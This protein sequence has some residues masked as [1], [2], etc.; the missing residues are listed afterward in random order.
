[1][2]SRRIAWL[3]IVVHLIGL[4]PLVLLLWRYWQGG[5]KP[6]PIGAAMRHT[7]RYALILLLLSL[8]PTALR[9][10][11]DR[12]D[13][14]R[15]R[16]AVGL[17]AFLYAA[18]HLLIYVGLDYAFSWKLLIQALPGATYVLL[19]LT[20][21]LLLVPLAITSTDGWV[22]RLGRHWRRLHRL[23]YPAA[24][25]VI[26]HYAG[27]F[28]ELRAGP[29]VAGALLAL[30]F[31]LRLPPVQQWSRTRLKPQHAPRPQGASGR[32]R[33]PGREQDDC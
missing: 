32:E 24:V 16:R 11:L 6:D 10:T 8:L 22:R 9:V 28:K 25:L 23:V 18:L 12:T 15:V 3:K 5:L 4:L 20:A 31:V 17:Y 33:K 30:L 21:F 26:L 29:V 19:G 14:L 13:L 1:M 7:G 2:R 27:V